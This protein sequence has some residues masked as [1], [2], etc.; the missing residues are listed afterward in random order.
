GIFHGSTYPDYSGSGS[1]FTTERNVDAKR[2]KRCLRPTQVPGERAGA[3]TPAGAKPGLADTFS[4]GPQKIGGASRPGA[5]FAHD[6]PHASSNWVRVDDALNSS[7]AVC[8]VRTSESPGRPQRGF[9]SRRPDGDIG[10]ARQPLEL[11]G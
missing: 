3:S 4:A 2:P 11:N 6:L 7:S 8:S 1:A 5:A 10:H 9:A